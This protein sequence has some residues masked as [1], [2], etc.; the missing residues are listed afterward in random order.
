VAESKRPA[1]QKVRRGEDGNWHV[2]LYKGTDPVT[3]R[4][5][6]PSRTWPGELPEAEAQALCDA[7]A[8]G[9]RPERRLGAM[10][11]DWI[12]DPVNGFSGNT[13][14]TYESALRCYVEPTLGAVPFD[15]LKA[16]DVDKAYRRLLT[17]SRGAPCIAPVTLRKVH[18]MLR[19]AY[20]GWAPD[21]DANPMLAVTPPRVA[22]PD[23]Y[24]L[25]EVE[26]ETLTGA[27]DAAMGEQSVTASNIARRTTAFAAYMALMQALRCGEVCALRR[28]DWRRELHDLHVGGTVVEHPSLQRQPRP[29]RNSVGNVALAR[30]TERRLLEHLVWQER[31]L[32]CPLTGRTPIVTYGV[33]GG[34]ARP[35]TVSKRFKV[36]AR[37]IGL[38]E[39]TVFHTLRHTSATWLLMHGFDARTI[40][41][42]LRHSDVS[43]TLR[44]Y[45]SVAPGRDAQ[46]ADAFSTRKGSI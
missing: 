15:E 23:P 4:R 38:P 37:E 9:V 21:L 14:A 13:V 18:S 45:S 20:R 41:E 28:G 1:S 12:G 44:F 25:D 26:L 39:E 36:F 46:A 30:E 27:L 5:I 31:W 11:A 7:W 29:K 42:R 3:G 32:V 2:R 43:T 19:A 16:S 22:F 6:R 17:G 33:R 10:L 35:S 40:Q 34:L 8:E 24:A